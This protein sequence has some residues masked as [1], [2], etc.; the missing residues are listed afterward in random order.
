M[1]LLPSDHVETDT[2]RDQVGFRFPH[3]II[4]ATNRTPSEEP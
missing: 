1:L 3:R 2:L 4:D